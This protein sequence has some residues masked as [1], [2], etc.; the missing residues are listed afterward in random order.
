MIDHYIDA[1]N[2]ALNDIMSVLTGLALPVAVGGGFLVVA[3]TVVLVFGRREGVEPVAWQRSLKTGGGYLVVALLLMVGWATLRMVRPLAQIDLLWRDRVEATRN[4]VRDALPVVQTGPAVAALVERTYTRDVTLPASVATRARREGIKAFAPYLGDGEDEGN[5]LKSSDTFHR[6]GGNLVYTHATTVQEEQP[7][8]FTNSQVKVAFAR[9]ANRAYDAD[10]EGRYTFVNTAKSEKPF[11]FLF[12]LPE[13]SLVR[14]LTVTVGDQKV[15]APSEGEDSNTYMWE[16][17][18]LPGATSEAVVRYR[19]AGARGWS[20]SLGSTRRRVE[21]FQLTTQP[22]G[23]LKFV[24]GSLQ[25][26]AQ[27]RGSVAWQLS[28]V[29]T[30]QRVALVFP[31]DGFKNLYLQALGAL[32]VSFVAF[33]AGITCFGL[34]LKRSFTPAQLGGGLALFA[35]GLGASATVCIYLGPIMGVVCAPLVGAA[36]AALLLGRQSLVVGVPVALLPAAFLSAENTG[37]IILLLTLLTLACM[38]A[39][40]YLGKGRPST[41]LASRSTNP[42]RPLAGS[43]ATS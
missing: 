20:Y 31:P 30:A 29:V 39:L 35:F 9:Q 16:G 41:P 7:Q 34:W 33:F 25:P 2:R 3:A 37:L 1:V 32:P 18:L 5:V 4:P 27:N 26:T 12:T 17:K 6:V 13:A 15:E 36:L 22:E 8:P 42:P 28:N 38:A 11:H 21:Q 43:P 10:F 24:R 23:D 14:D 19:V 40:R